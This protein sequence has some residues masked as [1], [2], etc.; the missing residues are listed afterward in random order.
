MG[1]FPTNERCRLSAPPMKGR[2]HCKN[3]RA[4]VTGIEQMVFL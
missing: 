4:R 1:F 2:V 3:Q